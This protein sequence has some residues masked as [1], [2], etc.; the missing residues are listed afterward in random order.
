MGQHLIFDLDGTLV[1]SCAICCEIVNLMLA[2]RGRA[3]RVDPVAARP[4]MSIGGARMIAALLGD[5]CGDPAVEIAR[6]R[7]IYATLDTSPA[8]LFPHVAS[9]LARLAQHGHILSICTN[10]PQNLAEKT[11]AD[12]GIAPLFAQVAGLTSGTPPKPAP[13]LLDGL[14]RDLGAQAGDCLFIGDSE[15][16]HQVARGAGM[17]FRFVTY[18]YA[19][20]DYVPPEASFDCFAALTDALLTRAY[21]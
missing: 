11:L 5:A 20:A 2:E 9:G 18:G 1:D 19:H 21:A 7:Q 10:K 14:L 4:W 3:E 17:G 15:V 16:D 8:S 6:F 12:T 13:D